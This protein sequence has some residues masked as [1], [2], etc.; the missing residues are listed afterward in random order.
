MGS[1]YILIII[2]VAG[3]SLII[4]GFILL[5][6]RNQ[7]RLL[8][9]QKAIAAAELDHQKKLLEAEITSQEAER[10]RIGKDL[11]DE[12]GSVLSSLRLL[13]ESHAEKSE[14]AEATTDFNSRSKIIIDRIIGNVRQ[15]SHNL[16][17]RIS[18][19]FGF[20]DALC[21][22]CDTINEAA[23]ISVS[24]DFKD[25][26]APLIIHDKTAMA[27]YRVLAELIN[28]TIKHA[29][30]TAIDIIVD[31]KENNLNICYADDGI[32]FSFNEKI[33]SGG[34]GL[35]NIES[36]LNMVQANWSFPASGVK[37]F[38]IEI[39]IPLK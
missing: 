19:K 30:A 13:I 11:H 35:Q 28:N 14:S 6:V 37:G 4:I 2:S 24:L 16:S 27:I 26:T 21:E 34:I 3:I 18:G 23:T 1:I 17:P 33:S 7:Q 31:I 10:L 39:L 36:R 20:Y 5:Q 8:Q 25:N 38:N 15:I 9:Q 22:L 29:K 12:V 32:G